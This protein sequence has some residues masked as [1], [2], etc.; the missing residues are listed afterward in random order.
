[1]PKGIYKRTQ[2]HRDILI[3]RNKSLSNR[4]K[5]SYS[6]LGHGFSQE[7]LQKLRDNHADFNGYK[8]PNWKGE[9]VGVGGVHTW[10]KRFFKKKMICEMCGIK[11]KDKIKIDWALKKGCKYERK[12]KNFIELCKK[13]HHKYDGIGFKKGHKINLGKKHWKM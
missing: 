8:N 11:H 2:Y 5:V 6:L 4:I 1:M 13:C 3:K 12:R 10:L 7:T 9:R